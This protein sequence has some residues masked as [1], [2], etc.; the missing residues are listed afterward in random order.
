MKSTAVIDVHLKD[1]GGR[2]VVDAVVC[3]PRTCPNACPGC[4]AD[5]DRR[6]YVGSRKRGSASLRR[7]DRDREYRPAAHIAFW[8]HRGAERFCPP[9]S[10]KDSARAWGCRPVWR[11][12]FGDSGYSDL[13][14]AR[15]FVEG[16]RKGCLRPQRLVRRRGCCRPCAANG[17]RQ[18][19]NPRTERLVL[20]P[21]V[22]FS[23]HGGR[24]LREGNVAGNL[25]LSF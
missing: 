2:D 6:E 20:V 5:S 1:V 8:T 24:D 13:R 18:Q 15:G 3:P 12:G 25:K 4:R 11:R 22:R 21:S 10:R 23:D 16:H 14:V 19:Q 7:D 17:S 9:G